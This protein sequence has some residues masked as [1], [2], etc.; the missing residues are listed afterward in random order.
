ML[1]LTSFSSMVCS[2]LRETI[3]IEVYRAVALK[4]DLSIST[5]KNF[6]NVREVREDD[7]FRRKRA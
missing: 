4:R 6:V 5:R 7:N 2:W 1:Q 3:I